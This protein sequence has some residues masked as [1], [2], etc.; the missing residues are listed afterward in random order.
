MPAKA[1]AFFTLTTLSAVKPFCDFFHITKD[2]FR[3][4]FTTPLFYATISTTKERSFAMKLKFDVAGR[5]QPDPFIFEDDGHYYIY[6]TGECGVECYEADDP[7]ATW[8]YLGRVMEAEGGSGYWAPSV[9]KYEGKYYM[10]V[11]FCE[12]GNFEHMHVAEA[13]SPRGPFV[14]ATKLYN[15]FSIDSHAVKTDA[16]L[17]LWYAEDSHEGERIGTRVF[18]DRLLDPYTPAN[19]RKE[20]IVPT[21]DE[22]RFTP[23]YTKECPWHTV[24]GAF[25]FE[26]DGWQY[27]MY[28]AGCYEDDTYHIGYAAEQTNEADHTKLRLEKHTDNGAFAPV[29]IKNA[30]EEGTGHHSVLC[31]K[32]EY[33]AVYHGRDYR[34][35][36][37]EG[38]V[39]ARTARICRLVV[40]DGIIT[41]ERYEDHI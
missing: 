41:A 26:K 23:K 10:Y 15:R 7:F 9:I 40:K 18:V 8:H 19:E 17:F 37:S 33:Y 34:K 6:A 11:S 21:F 20:M 30:F 31:Y 32:G 39:E 36:T 29:L 25:W 14:N 28:S 38:Y 5:T 22:E 16:G 4:L 35:D 27:V 1:A 3:L 2:F 24:E 12:N 13:E